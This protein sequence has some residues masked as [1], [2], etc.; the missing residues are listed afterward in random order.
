MTQTLDETIRMPRCRTTIGSSTCWSTA[1]WR[2]ASAASFCPVWTTG[3]ADGVAV[4]WRFSK[5]NRGG[6]SWARWRGRLSRTP[7][8]QN[9]GRRRNEKPSRGGRGQRR[10]PGWITTMLGMAA[11]FLLAVG[12]T[13]VDAETCSGRRRLAPSGQWPNVGAASAARGAGTRRPCAG[14]PAG[15]RQRASGQLGGDGSRRPAQHGQI[16]RRLAR[17]T[18][19]GLASERPDGDS[20]RRCSRASNTPA[21]MYA[22]RGSCFRFGCRTV[23]G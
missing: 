17:A 15:Q 9:A 23:V 20:R 2:N 7:G 22:A 21:T 3:R 10:S 18:R 4:R 1:S 19:R 12:L 11:S 13:I 6:G 5:P 16:A 8:E 14:T